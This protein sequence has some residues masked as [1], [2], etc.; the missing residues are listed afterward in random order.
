MPSFG[1]YT[2]EGT[3]AS[4][5]KPTGAVVEAGE[6]VA[7][8]E[9]DKVMAEVTAPVE[10]ILHHV[11]SPGAQLEVE[12]LIGY[13]L[14]PGETP[15]SLPDPETSTQQAVAPQ[16]TRRLEERVGSEGIASPNARRI[17][18]ELGVDLATVAGTGPGGRVTEADVR[19]AAAREG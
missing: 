14:A 3:L 17:A 7:E 8:I 19:A 18:A 2:A 1:M 9:T 15:P 16:P 6:V 5:L 12:T 11:L 4:W 10:G 13:V